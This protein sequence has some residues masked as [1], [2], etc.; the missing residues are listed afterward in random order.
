MEIKD[1]DY[2]SELA[3][4]YALDYGIDDWQV[5]GNTLVY[6]DYE[7]DPQSD[8]LKS[9][10]RRINLDTGKDIKQESLI[11]SK[12]SDLSDFI[13]DSAEYHYT[14]D[15]AID[16]F[17]VFELMCNNEGFDVDENDFAEYLDYIAEFEEE[18]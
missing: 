3:Y 2:Y 9:V 14:Y 17:G 8:D 11:E 4:E 1:Q 16:D 7:F 5:E 15:E 10:E 13:R 18:N 6:Y 12:A